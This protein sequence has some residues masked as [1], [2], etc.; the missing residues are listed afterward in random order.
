MSKLVYREETTIHDRKDAILSPYYS[1]E[2][3]RAWSVFVGENNVSLVEAILKVGLNKYSGRE[4]YRW[5]TELRYVLSRNKNGLLVPIKMVGKQYGDPS[6]V[7]SLARQDLWVSEVRRVFSDE[8][9]KK[10]GV[11]TLK[12]VYP[13]A[14]MYNL[15]GYYEM[16]PT[17]IHA[18]RQPV[19][20]DFVAEVFGKKNMRKDLV[21]A[22]ATSTPISVALAAQFKGLVPIDWII[23][24]L[25]NNPRSEFYNPEDRTVT[26]SLSKI[27]PILTQLDPRSYR[28]LLS[29]NMHPNSWYHITDTVRWSD[30]IEHPYFVRSWDDL[31][32]QL[33]RGY[34]KDPFEDQEIK[35]NAL[36][37]RLNNAETKNFRIVPAHHTSIMTKWGDK[38]NNCIATYRRTALEGKNVYAGIY[39]GEKLKANMEIADGTLRQLLGTNNT[40]MKPDARDEIVSLLREKGVVV[41]DRYWGSESWS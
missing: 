5:D 15:S 38:M 33:Y 7:F 27:R 39:V 2:L 26:R 32:R 30:R 4:W 20:K 11:I 23:N 24:F 34:V 40:P 1:T 14:G 12:S 31:H 18:M 28:R 41:P 22:C 3:R 25:R 10:F 36:A 17:I 29:L 37:K 8:V 21:K 16:P 9:E 19:F 13:V 35:L 6:Y